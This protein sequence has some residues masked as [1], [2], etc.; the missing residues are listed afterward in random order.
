M[1]DELIATDP[2]D[3]SR[4]WSHKLEGD[5]HQDGGALGTPPV[6]A[7][8]HLVIATLHG[9][10]LEIDQKT[11]KTEATFEVG[12]TLRAQ[13]VVV[14]GW[15]YVG[16]ED[17]RLVAIDTGDATLTGWPMWGGNAARTGAAK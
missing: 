9:K 12:G 3:G 17:G 16:T 10:V 5:M 4:V 8:G 6:A 14:D 7:G 11:G 15:I 2:E 13:P 1:G